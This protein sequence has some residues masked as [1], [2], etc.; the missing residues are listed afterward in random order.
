MEG[1]SASPTI[2][3][4]FGDSGYLRSLRGTT[5]VYGTVLWAYSAVDNEKNQHCDM[6]RSRTGNSSAGCRD[7]RRR[8]QLVDH[9]VPVGDRDHGRPDG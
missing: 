1:A 8:N 2:Q 9:A 4:S 5:D 3:Q 7:G 6:R